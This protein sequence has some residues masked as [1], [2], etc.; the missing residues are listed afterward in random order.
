M[1][2]VDEETRAIVRNARLESLEADN[3]GIDEADCITD[4]ADLKDELY[5]DEKVKV[6]HIIKLYNQWLT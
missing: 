6:N 2:H 5:I 1:T 4:Q 3:Y